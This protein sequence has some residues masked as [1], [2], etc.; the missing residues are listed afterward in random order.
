M[1][2]RNIKKDLEIE[3]WVKPREGRFSEYGTKRLISLILQ[4]VKT[5]KINI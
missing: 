2:L 3:G 1:I 5:N 4:G